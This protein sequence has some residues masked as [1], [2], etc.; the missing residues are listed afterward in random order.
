MIRR[1]EKKDIENVLPLILVILKDMELDFLIRYGEETTLEV[2]RQG[3]V[4]EGFRYYYKRA[5]VAV[6]NEEV[7][8]VAFGYPDTEE[9][10]IDA[11]LKNIFSSLGIDSDEKMFVDKEAGENQWYLDSIAVRDD[12]RGK[13]IGGQLLSALPE[14]IDETK[15]IGLNVD[16]ANP[17]AK[18]LY[19]RFGFVDAGEMII[20]GHKYDHMLRE[21][22]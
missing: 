1:A 20:S 9:S 10:I 5:I 17:K 14:F 7:V 13:G 16:K 8:G 15:H 4:S 12:Q 22:N 3:Y 18:K 11:P 19:R 21:L 2:L 6:E